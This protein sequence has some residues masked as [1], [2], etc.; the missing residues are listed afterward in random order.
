MQAY[1]RFLLV[2]LM[3]ISHAGT[4]QRIL[5]FRGSFLMSFSEGNA[6]QKK[7]WPFHCTT[8]VTKTGIE[9]KDDMNAKGVNKRIIYNLLDSSWL[10]LL[11]YNNVK[12][13]TRIHA[14]A[15]FSDKMV[16]PKVSMRLTHETKLIDGYRCDKYI[17][18]SEKDSAVVWV[19]A[20][21]NFDLC[22]LYKMLAHCGMMSSYVD[23]G[24]WYF[25]KQ[26]RG[27]VL[28]VT[29]Y[30]KSNGT[31]YS[32]LISGIQQNEIIIPYFDLAGYKITDIAP[33]ENCGQ[34]ATEPEIKK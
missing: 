15:M 5:P 21:F 31:S 1:F 18:E 10:M 32:M 23:D 29:S 16:V 20:E 7:A 24:T 9:I 3:A 2:L 6:S 30:S 4:A 34:V 17:I 19:A 8:D 22:K 12:Q 13:A 33:G 27:M 26:I 14:N 25:A 28:E 11:S